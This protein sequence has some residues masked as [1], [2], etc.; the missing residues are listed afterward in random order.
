MIAHAL[1]NPFDISTTLSFCR[2]HGLWLVED[3]CDAL[4]CSYS[5][6]K[7]LA[8]ALGFTENSPGLDEGP[9]RIVRWTGTWGDIS[10]Q[11]FYHRTTSPWVRGCGKHRARSEAQSDRREFPRLGPRLLVS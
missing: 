7:E 11:S 9:D 6:P 4:G 3:N 8:E 5:M 2:K 10:T 1:G